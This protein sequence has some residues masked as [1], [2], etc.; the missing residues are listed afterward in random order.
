MARKMTEWL[1]KCGPITII[2]KSDGC[3]RDTVPMVVGLR[4]NFYEFDVIWKMS[5]F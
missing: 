3:K 5:S 4:Y 1:S 2:M